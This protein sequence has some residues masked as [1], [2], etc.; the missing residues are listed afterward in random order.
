MLGIVTASSAVLAL[1]YFPLREQINALIKLPTSLIVL[2]L[3]TCWI[4]PATTMWTMKQRYEYKYRIA[5]FIAVGSA[6]LAQIVSIAAVVTFRGQEGVNLAHIRLWSAGI[7]NIAVGAALFVYI[8]VQGRTFVDLHLWRLTLPVAIPLIPH[9]L[10]SVILSSTD[11]IMISSMIDKSTAGIYSLAATLSSIGVLFWRALSVTFSPFINTKL[12]RREFSTIGKTIQPLLVTAGLT[13]V[14]GALAAPEIIRILATKE[15]LKGV[16]VVPA[17]V[18]GIYLHSMYDIFSAVSFFHKKSFRIMIASIT[19][20][21]VNLVL[22]YF[23]IK[24]YGFIAAGYT[25]LIAN[26]VLTVMHY[27]N[28]RHIEK[29]KIYDLKFVVLSVLAV[30]AASLMC[31]FLYGMSF[32]VRYAIIILI[33]A[34]MVWKHRVLIRAI[35]DMKV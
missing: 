15:Y 14:L 29:E 13:C 8:L 9:Y 6:L 11:K 10:S 23:C 20:A 17:I 31:N 2:L 28:M 12:E 35:N 7:V 32:I 27:F 4:Q 25:T 19:A 33:L 22:N 16:Y 18:S 30:T 1:I 34:F 24:A 5:F 3:L 26:L 21:I